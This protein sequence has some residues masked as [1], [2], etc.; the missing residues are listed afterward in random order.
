MPRR[1]A[2]ALCDEELFRLR[3]LV[4]ARRQIQR[5]G[6]TPTKGLDDLNGVLDLAL[7][8]SLRI[9]EILAISRGQ[10]EL[11]AAGRVIPLASDAVVISRHRFADGRHIA[12]ITRTGGRL[13]QN[14]VRRTLRELIASTEFKGWLTPHTAR[15]TNL[16]LVYRTHGAQVASQVAGHKG[17]QLIHSAYAVRTYT[18]PDVRNL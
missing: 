10:V 9:S 17:E 2:R 16:T 18:A 4:D 12:F 1:R 5:S 7:F 8:T 3:K 6:P 13:S 15:K 11:E 14:N